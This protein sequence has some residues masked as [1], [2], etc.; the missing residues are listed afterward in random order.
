MLEVT[1]SASENSDRVPSEFSVEKFLPFKSPGSCGPT[2]CF[3]LS[4][5]LFFHPI[6]ETNWML[7]FNGKHFSSP[8]FYFNRVPPACTSPPPAAG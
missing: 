2:I 6:V 1:A 4:P 7:P 3:L 5:S 8:N